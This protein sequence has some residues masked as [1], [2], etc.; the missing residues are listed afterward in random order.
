MGS[1]LE[2][3][4]VLPLVPDVAVDLVVDV[5]VADAVDVD[6]VVLVVDEPATV[7][8]DVVADAVDVLVADTDPLPTVKSRKPIWFGVALVPPSLASTPT[9]AGERVPVRL[10]VVAGSSAATSANV[11]VL[12]LVL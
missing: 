2:V 6:V 8:L 11:Q 4:E 1:L 10:V 9:Y 5:V 3:E 7:L 12:P